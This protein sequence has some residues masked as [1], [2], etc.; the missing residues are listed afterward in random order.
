MT[1]EGSEKK[2]EKK[3]PKLNSKTTLLS[4]KG[5]CQHAKLEIGETKIRLVLTVYLS[6]NYFNRGWKVI[7]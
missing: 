3:A 2:N 1:T 6:G 5:A 4:P 7:H